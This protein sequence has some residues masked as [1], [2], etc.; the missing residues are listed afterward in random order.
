MIFWY[1][2]ISSQG[3]LSRAIMAIL[4]CRLFELSSLNGLY[5]IKHV[6]SIT[7]TYLYNSDIWLYLGCI[8]IRSRQYVAQECLNYLP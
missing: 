5:W 8:Y 7:L 6:H 4:P 1:T 3:N 2:Y